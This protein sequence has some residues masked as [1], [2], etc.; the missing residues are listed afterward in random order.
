MKIGILADIHFK[1]SKNI[2]DRLEMCKQSL[3][4]AYQQFEKENVDLIVNLGDVYDSSVVSAETIQTVS[5]VY[6]EHPDIHEIVVSGNHDS[7]NYLNTVVSH[8]NIHNNVE[9]VT[10]PQKTL[11]LSFLPYRKIKDI[12][13]DLIKELSNDIL[14]S[15]IDINKSTSGSGFRLPGVEPDLLSDNFEHVFNGHIHHGEM[16]TQNVSNVG[17]LVCHSFSDRHLANPGITIYDTESKT[18]KL[19]ENPFTYFFETVKGSTEVE[20]MNKLREIQTREQRTILRVIVPVHLRDF[21]KDLLLTKKF[22]NTRVLTA[23]S[24]KTDVNDSINKQAINQIDLK[25]EFNEFLTT[26][27]DKKSLKGTVEQYRREALDD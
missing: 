5:E 17:S 20:L 7:F 11:G 24:E 9:V 2:F 27:V 25:K 1:A 16:I 3:I 6:G 14:F 23:A 4:W 22:V 26:S 21:T 18:S 13:E 19:I 12:T 10:K 15:H 8:L